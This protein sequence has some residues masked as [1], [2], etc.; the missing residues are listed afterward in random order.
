[1][2]VS[3]SSSSSS[4]RIASINRPFQ[5]RVLNLKSFDFNVLNVV[6]SFCLFVTL[7]FQICYS[8]FL[9]PLLRFF[10]LLQH[11]NHF[12]AAFFPICLQFSRSFKA[13]FF[14]IY[15]VFF[16]YLFAAFFLT[17]LFLDF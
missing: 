4:N 14:F 1:M 17:F 12:F 2:P 9:L 5:V 15:S 10:S 6:A 13:S 3:S 16:S 11:F 7:T 8:S